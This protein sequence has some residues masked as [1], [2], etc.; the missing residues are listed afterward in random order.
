MKTLASAVA[1]VLVAATA[2]VAQTQGLPAT[3][4]N[5]VGSIGNLSMYTQREVPFWNETIPRESGGR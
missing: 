2:A 4:F 5:V 1:A 3:T